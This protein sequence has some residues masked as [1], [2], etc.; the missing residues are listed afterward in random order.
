MLNNQLIVEFWNEIRHF[1]NTVD[2]PEAAETLVNLL[3]DND[4]DADDIK[5][6]FKH[7]NDVKRVLKSFVDQNAEEDDYYDDSDD[8]YDDED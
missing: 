6:M 3:I 7:D 5:S 1:I 4:I 8:A 2:R